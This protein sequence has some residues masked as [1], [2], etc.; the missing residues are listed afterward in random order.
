MYTCNIHHTCKQLQVLRRGMHAAP[1]PSEDAS[2]GSV[3]SILHPL[4][5]PVS[6]QSPPHDSVAGE[7]TSQQREE[8]GEEK[9]E[10]EE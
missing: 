9:R 8:E 3:V 1:L 10:S 7:E 2:V 5:L 4:Q 6:D